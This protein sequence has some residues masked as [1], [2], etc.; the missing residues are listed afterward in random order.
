MFA[1][2]EIKTWTPGREKDMAFLVQPELGF[3]LGGN[4][5]GVAPARANGMV[6]L[7][8]L[9]EFFFFLFIYFTLCRG[10]RNRSC[11]TKK[12]SSFSFPP[13]SGSYLLQT[14]PPLSF[15][16]EP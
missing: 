9:L 14:P 4:P 7:A 8:L 12:I 1:T 11:N 6:N 2:F 16:R 10:F 5:R 3:G 15:S 13:P